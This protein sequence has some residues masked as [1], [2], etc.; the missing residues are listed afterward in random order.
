LSISFIKEIYEE[1]NIPL[2][3]QRNYE[4]TIRLIEEDGVAPQVY[5]LLKE[6]GMLGNTPPYFK[7]RL[8]K[9]YQESLYLNL[10]IRSQQ[11]RILE[12]FEESHVEVIPLKGTLFAEKYFGD[13]GARPTSDIDLLIKVK[14][15]PEAIRI[16]KSLGFCMEQEQIDDHFHISLNKNIPGSSVP[17]TVELHWELVWK[18][19][20]NL[21]IDDFWNGALPSGQNRFR[22]ELSGYHTFYLMCLHGWRHNMDSTKY[23]LDIIRMIEH[24]GDKL[25]YM[26]LFADAKRHRTFKRMIRT[27]SIVYYHFPNLDTI[28]PLPFKKYAVWW[29]THPVLKNQHPKKVEKYIDFIDYQFLTYDTMTH[30]IR[31]IVNWLCSGTKRKLIGK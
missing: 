10:Y 8:S 22:K 30:T 5:F 26:E 9:L 16:V 7:E 28:E 25:D 19:T 20:A 4:K 23:F 6:K 1:T 13:L 11:I 18:R 3:E 21:R 24:L 12:C 31:E 29:E 2:P 15:L 27:L 14:D 17:L